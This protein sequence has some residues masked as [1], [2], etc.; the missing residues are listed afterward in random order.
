MIKGS[1]FRSLGC[2]GLL[3]NEILTQT[4]KYIPNSSISIKLSYIDWEDET[5][6]IRRNNFYEKFNF[7]LK[8]NDERECT[9]SGKLPLKDVTL[10]SIEDLGFRE[11]NIEDYLE[12]LAQD[13]SFCIKKTN[14]LQSEIKGK[15]GFIK[16]QSESMQKHI[17]KMIFWR[18]FSIALIVTILTMLFF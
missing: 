18:R 10:Y 3:M 17:K 1:A 9:G 12:N 4:K 2:G 16:F 6:R 13:N 11:I 7:S 5:N 8:F 14:E 15:K